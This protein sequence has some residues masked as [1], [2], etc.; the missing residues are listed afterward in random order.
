ML[1]EAIKVSVLTSV[2]AFSVVLVIEVGI[3]V[4]ANVAV[5]LADPV[6]VDMLVVW[7]GVVTLD[8]DI[9]NSEAVVLRTDGMRSA[10]VL[11]ALCFVV[12]AAVAV[13]VAAFSSVAFRLVVGTDIDVAWRVVPGDVGLLGLFIVVL[14]MLT[15]LEVVG[16]IV[17]VC[18]VM[19]KSDG[20][21][22]LDVV[23]DET[24]AS[25]LAVVDDLVA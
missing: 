15:T 3:F 18:N 4:T 20:S 13:V 16:V 10:T 21:P 5:L 1:P 9:V 2:D 7:L 8:V 12:V 11:V 17:E 6:A 22:S 24:F 19:L 23:L 14:L 25:V